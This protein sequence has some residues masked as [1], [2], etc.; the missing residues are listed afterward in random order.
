MPVISL[1]QMVC[2]SNCVLF[3]PYAYCLVSIIAY[4]Q[5]CHIL[6]QIMFVFALAPAVMVYTTQLITPH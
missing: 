2:V 6:I 4:R 3:I 1:L 5:F